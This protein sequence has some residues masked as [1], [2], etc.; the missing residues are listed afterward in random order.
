M[1]QFYSTKLAKNGRKSKHPQKIKHTP[2]ATKNIPIVEGIAI[3][4][5][6]KAD[7]N[8]HIVITKVNCFLF[9]FVRFIW[10]YE[11]VGKMFQRNSFVISFFSTISSFKKRNCGS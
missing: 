2:K 11:F 6:V 7:K 10:L 4:T 8:I 1:F 3:K 9:M 5:A